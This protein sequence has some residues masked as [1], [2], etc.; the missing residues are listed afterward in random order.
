MTSLL[1]DIFDAVMGVLSLG[2]GVVLMIAAVLLAGVF[3]WYR[4]PALMGYAATLL[5]MAIGAVTYGK[6]V[7]YMNAQDVFIARQA[8]D[9]AA[10]NARI[11][12]LATLLNTK[13]EQYASV[14]LELQEAQAE[15]AKNMDRAINDLFLTPE[16]VNETPAQ[17]KSK[18]VVC[19]DAVIPDSIVRNLQVRGTPGP[20]RNTTDRRQ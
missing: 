6:Q 12:E 18:S 7:G 4:L 11:L 3:L 8:K 14:R 5:V 20:V 19:I 13:N 2:M 10:E 1:I 16:I 9:R 15:N 17:K